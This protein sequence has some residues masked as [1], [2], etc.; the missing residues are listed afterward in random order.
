MT[1]KGECYRTNVI[2]AWNGTVVNNGVSDDYGNYVIVDYGSGIKFVY[3]SLQE[4]SIMVK[5]GDRINKGQLIGKVDKTNN[6]CMLY[7][8]VRLNDQTVNPNEYISKESV[9]PTFGDKVIYVEGSTVKETVCLS[10]IE[11]GYSID[12]VAGI[13]ANMQRESNFNLH[14]IGDGGTSVGLVQWHSGRWDNLNNYCNQNIYNAECQLNFMLY[15]LKNNYKS[16]YSYI[17]GNYSAYDIAYKFCYNY[18][19]PAAR[20]TSC[21]KRGEL[22]RDT[23]ISYVS[24]GCR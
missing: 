10:L 18:E 3:G 22:A 11:S 21:A 16:V 4:S 17:I 13:M 19:I 2:S 9:R 6:E 7:L 14:T 1:I 15:E 8:E 24:N 5:I 20:D 12:T 23:Y